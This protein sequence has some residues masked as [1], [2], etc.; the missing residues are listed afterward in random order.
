MNIACIIPARGNSK[1]IKDKNIMDFCGKPLIV[2]SIEQALNTKY[3]SKVHVSSDSERILSISENN[4][5]EKIRRPDEIALDESTSEE[6]LIHAI[7]IIEN[8]GSNKIDLVVFLQATSPLRDSKDIDAAIDIF[9]KEDLDSLFSVCDL[10]DLM[11]WKKINN[12]LQSINYNYMNRERRQDIEKQYGE[13]GSIYIFKPQMIKKCM[14]RISG[15]IGTYVMDTWKI[16]EIDNK[17]DI[18]IC[19]YFMNTKKLI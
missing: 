9:I 16:Y 17:E 3:I 13:N 8:N 4:G 2:W 10:K 12:R 11:V 18:E 14:N 19:E 6:A 15:K 5:A 1:E 7:N